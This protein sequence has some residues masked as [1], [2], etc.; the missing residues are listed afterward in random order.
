MNI[1]KILNN[2]EIGNTYID[3]NAN[4]RMTG[5]ENYPIYASKSD[6]TGISIAQ[7]LQRLQIFST[8]K[9]YLTFG[10]CYSKAKIVHNIV[11]RLFPD[12][13]VLAKGAMRIYCKETECLYGFN[14]NPPLEYHTWLQLKNKTGNPYIVDMALPGVILRGSASGD[15][16]GKFI[17]GMPPFAYVGHTGDDY[18]I[19]YQAKE[20]E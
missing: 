4:N 9:G 2:N 17:T 15:E 14:W 19:W 12:K 16:H 18:G 8:F 6:P 3:V 20:V 10:D 7:E 5:E 11:N 1:Q 13:F